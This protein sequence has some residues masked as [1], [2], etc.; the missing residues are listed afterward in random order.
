MEKGMKSEVKKKDHINSHCL[1]PG[2]GYVAMFILSNL[3]FPSV[4]RDPVSIYI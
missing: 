2:H 1:H 3:F 4:Y